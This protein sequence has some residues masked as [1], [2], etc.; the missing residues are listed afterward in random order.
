MN[1]AQFNTRTRA[2]NNTLYWLSQIVGA[3]VCGYAL[4]YSGVKRTVRAKASLV[5]LFV[6][7]F[8]IW[9]GGWAWQKKQATR[10]VVEDEVNV[11]VKVDWTEGGDKFVGPMFLYFFYG[12]YD[13]AWQTCIYW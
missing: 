11:F 1:G 12:F 13:A 10:G 9:G 3:I 5:F 4:D 8:A 2:L 7:T 6:I